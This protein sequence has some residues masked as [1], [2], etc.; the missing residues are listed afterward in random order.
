[1]N[2]KLIIMRGLP[3]SGKSSLAEGIRNVAAN[4]GARTTAI[5]S[6]DDYFIEGDGVYRFKPQEIGRAHAFNQKAC[7]TN[8]EDECELIII[9][10]TNTQYWEMK[11]YVRLAQEHGYVIEFQEPK[12]EWAWEVEECAKRNTHQVPLK[13]IQQMKDRYQRTDGVSGFDLL[14][15]IG[16]SKAPWEK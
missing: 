11:P 1:M 7:Q 8:M 15:A 16:L 6:T 9:D 2:K 13:S 10:N 4:R 14:I 12:T 3:G 5:L